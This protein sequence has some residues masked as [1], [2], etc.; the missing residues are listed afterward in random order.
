VVSWKVIFG[1]RGG[2]EFKM[3]MWEFKRIYDKE[4][5]KK[6]RKITPEEVFKLLTIESQY[7][8][9]EEIKEP[10]KLLS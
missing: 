1:I 8:D 6:H 7:I 4:C 2:Q 10:Q 5:V 3:D 9:F